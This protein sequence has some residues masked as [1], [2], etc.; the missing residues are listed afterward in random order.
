[1]QLLLFQGAL[2][3]Q[4]SAPMRAKCSRRR[5]EEVTV[6]FPFFSASG[7]EGHAARAERQSTSGA[8][9][10]SEH[11]RSGQWNR[12]MVRL[13]RPLREEAGPRVGGHAD[14]P[15]SGKPALC[16]HCPEGLCQTGHAHVST[17]RLAEE[18][19][20]GAL[21]RLGGA[22]KQEPSPHQTGCSPEGR[23]YVSLC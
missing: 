7:T 11:C 12:L 19:R 23:D 15:S 3:S 1:M 5:G 22:C 20:T 2:W 8:S 4:H 18:E 21:V 10:A 16:A 14:T 6:G 17:I 13:V 9:L